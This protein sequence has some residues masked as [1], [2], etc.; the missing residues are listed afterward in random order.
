MPTLTYNSDTPRGGPLNSRVLIGRRLSHGLMLGDPGV[1]RLHAWIDPVNNADTQWIVADAGSKTGTF[2]NDQQIT[3]HALRDGDRIR[4][5]KTTITYHDTDELPL[6][7]AAMEWSAPANTVFGEGILFE[8]TCGSPMWVSNELAGKRGICRHCRKPVA[9]PTIEIPAP[10]PAPSSV[11]AAIEPPAPAVK[12]VLAKHGAKCAVCHSTINEGEEITQCGD[13]AMTYHTECW[14]ENLGCSSYGCPQVEA[15][16]PRET[17]VA[18]TTPAEA[19]PTT[20]PDE[21]SQTPW[22]VV[23]LAASVVGSVIGAWAFG[24]IAAIVAVLSLILLIR[25]KQRRPMLLVAAIVLSI[26]GIAIGLGV[27]DIWYLN[28]RHLPAM[29]VR[30]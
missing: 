3:R 18:V 12:P 14:Q 23:L 22:D 30:H 8:C 7:T 16:K 4:V 1:S 21:S 10:I 26:G 17:P 5:G 20:E 25:G 19:Q 6:G 27:S 15:L 2:V 11:P 24:S 28:A 9:V 29:L 13:C